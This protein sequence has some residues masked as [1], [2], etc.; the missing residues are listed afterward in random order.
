MIFPF[1][2]RIHALPDNL[3][4][5][6]KLLGTLSTEKFIMQLP[7]DRLFPNGIPR[8]MLLTFG[9][10]PTRGGST[11]ATTF[12]NCRWQVEPTSFSSSSSGLRLTWQSS[13]EGWFKTWST[14]VSPLMLCWL[15]SDDFITLPDPSYECSSS[16]SSGAWEPV[17]PASTISE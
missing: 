3:E 6:K 13:S 11:I 12:R 1:S 15:C 5:K 2:E 17:T 7:I 9:W 10:S 4:K 14:I 8:W 16:V